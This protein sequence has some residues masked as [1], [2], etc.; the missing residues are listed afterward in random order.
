MALGT[1]LLSNTTGVQNLS[2]RLSV[3]FTGTL[4][5]LSVLLD[6]FAPATGINDQL[7]PL[8]QTDLMV[9]HPPIV[10]AFYTLCIIP[11][12]VSVSGSIL[13]S[14]QTSIHEATLPWSR[15]AFVVGT[16]GIGLGGLWAYTVLDLSLI[17]I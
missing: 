10:F 4:I 3:G 9:I 14:D 11:A 2:L 6:P 8:L 12:L 16:A 13:G 15:A 1:H 7:N 5:G 17:H